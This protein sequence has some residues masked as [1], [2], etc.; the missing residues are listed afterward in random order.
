MKSTVV[1]GS[2]TSDAGNAVC[3]A[4]MVPPAKT[5]M[6]ELPTATAAVAPTRP[7][8]KEAVFARVR[9]MSV[10]VA[11]TSTVVAAL[12]SDSAARS[13]V[14]F[15]LWIVTAAEKETLSALTD[16]RPVL[17]CARAWIVVEL[18]TREVR[19]TPALVDSIWVF[20]AILSDETAS[21]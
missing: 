1:V 12:T 7:S 9:L 14:A 16:L 13:T 11:R 18:S 19:L 15:E 4:S 20:S 17:R 5:S 10:P 21:L 3:P 2:N 6:I 8:L